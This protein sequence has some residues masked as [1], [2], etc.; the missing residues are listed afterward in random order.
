[1]APP[2]IETKP[3]HEPV[4][5]L[6]YSR[7]ANRRWCTLREFKS[8]MRESTKKTMLTFSCFFAT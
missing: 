7:V 3:V 2:Q 6:W 1:M 4:K 5:S 8:H